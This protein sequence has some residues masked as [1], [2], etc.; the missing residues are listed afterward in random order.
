MIKTLRD[1]QDMLPSLDA[2]IY[3]LRNDS[4]SDLLRVH[5]CLLEWY[6]DTEQWYDDDVS[7]ETEEVVGAIQDVQI[8]VYCELRYRNIDVSLPWH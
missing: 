3:N 4:T 6:K 7:A 8:M 5:A 2:P 1:L